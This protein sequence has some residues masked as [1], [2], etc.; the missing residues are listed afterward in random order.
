MKPRTKI[1]CTK[2]NKEISLSNLKKHTNICTG[3]IKISISIA[4]YLQENGMYRCPTCEKEYT[5]LGIGSHIWKNHTEIGKL[6]SNRGLKNGTY[7]IWNKGKKASPE[8]IKNM[9]LAQIGH[10][11]HPHSP[12]TK[13]KLSEKRL[14][15]IKEGKVK[16][17][18]TMSKNSYPEKYFE[19]VLIDLNIKFER[20]YHVINHKKNYFLD[21]LID[22][23]LDLEIDGAQHKFKDRIESDIIR[24][25]FV[26]SFGFDIFRI[27]WKSPNTKIGHDYLVEKIN[28]LKIKLGL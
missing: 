9:S 19:E 26:R 25:A 16:T 28:E 22:G 27:E 2:C 7:I 12:E 13:K 21:F 17:W 20:Q 15:L 11:G 6:N 23:K 4:P 8:A 5:K 14:Q 3:K 10:P 24:D 1:S 18:S